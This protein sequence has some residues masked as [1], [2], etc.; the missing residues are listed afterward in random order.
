MMMNLLC[1]R[2]L[3]WVKVLV[4]TR[5]AEYAAPGFCLSSCLSFTLKPLCQILSFFLFY[6]HVMYEMFKKFS[7]SN[8]HSPRPQWHLRIPKPAR[9]WLNAPI[10]HL[11]MV[12]L[13][14]SGHHGSSDSCLASRPLSDQT[15]TKACVM[16][17]SG[18]CIFICDIKNSSGAPQVLPSSPWNT[19]HTV[20]HVTAEWTWL[21]SAGDSIS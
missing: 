16:T 19:L 10:S 21:G 18:I 2:L 3:T 17:F 20:P 1:Q 4:V 14:F 9:F 5:G 7:L 13:V 8:R 12:E 6:L 15:M 11:L